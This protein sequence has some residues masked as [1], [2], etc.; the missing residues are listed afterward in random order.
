MKYDMKQ[1]LSRYSARKLLRAGWAAR[2]LTATVMLMMAVVAPVNVS[3]GY[4]AAASDESLAAVVELAD[5]SDGREAKAA[6]KRRERREQADVLAAQ[7]LLRAREAEDGITAAMQQLETEGSYLEGLENRFKSADSLSGKILADADA[8][9]ESLDTAAGA[10]SDVLRY[11]LVVDEKSYA[12]R[13]PKALHQLEASGF[14]VIKFRN[15]WG[16]KFY[17]GINA[18]LMSPEGV[19]VELQFHTAQSYAI[20]QVSHEVYEIRRNPKA[21]EDERAEATRMSVVYNNHVIMPDGADKVTWEGKTG[22]AA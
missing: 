5:F 13:V 17:Q 20:K 15:A 11:T 14:T 8:N 1:K 18:Q 6:G 21:S 10:I 2:T 16:G 3:R 12:D 19:R 9:L 4:A 7:L 22:Q